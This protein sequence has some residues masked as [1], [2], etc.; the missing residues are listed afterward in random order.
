MGQ[1]SVPIVAS[2]KT[3]ERPAGLNCNFVHRQFLIERIFY[4]DMPVFDFSFPF[5]SFPMLATSA[6]SI[7]KGYPFRKNPRFDAMRRT[8][9]FSCW[10]SPK[11]FCVLSFN[12]PSERQLL[13]HFSPH[14]IQHCT[15]DFAKATRKIFEKLLFFFLYSIESKRLS[16]IPLG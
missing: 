16:V 8:G 13:L 9:I 15:F 5:H 7:G 4:N 11:P 3:I 1:A 6:A 2:R 14:Y 10:D 12:I